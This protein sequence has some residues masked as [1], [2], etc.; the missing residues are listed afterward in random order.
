MKFSLLLAFVLVSQLAKPAICAATVKSKL[1]CAMG[2]VRCENLLKFENCVTLLNFFFL[3]SLQSS[4]TYGQAPE[5]LAQLLEPYWG[6]N[7]E[8]KDYVIVKLYTRENG[9]GEAL[10]LDDELGLHKSSFNFNRPTKVITHGY[11]NSGNSPSCKLMKDGNL[12]IDFLF[13]VS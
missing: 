1:S 10:I 12:K 6:S 13:G 7:Y 9:D 11:L 3:F 5:A 8:I 4:K 2:I